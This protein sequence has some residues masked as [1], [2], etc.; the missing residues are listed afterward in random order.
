MTSAVVYFGDVLFCNLDLGSRVAVKKGTAQLC[1]LI[2]PKC[3]RFVPADREHEGAGVV[4]EGAVWS[5]KKKCGRWPVFR[6]PCFVLSAL[7]GCEVLL[8]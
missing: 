8:V 5:S 6:F 1:L 2:G 4:T 7:H 3:G